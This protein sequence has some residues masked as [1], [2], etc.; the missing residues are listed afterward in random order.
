MSRVRVLI[1]DDSVVVR[2]ILS[3]VLG[4][5]PWIEI[6][7]TAANGRIAVQKLPQLAPDL[8]TLDVEM[9]EL[10]GLETLVEIRRTHPKLPVIMFSTLTERAAST[11]LEAL[12]RG[13]TDYA[14][15]PQSSGG[16][17]GASAEIRAQLLPKIKALFPNRQSLAPRGTRSSVAPPRTASQQVRAIAPV[18]RLPDTLRSGPRGP[19]QLLAIGGSTG[20]P[21]ALA[22]VFAKLPPLNIP[23]VITQ[24]MPPLF[25]RLLSER[26]SSQSKHR[27]IEAKGD[28][29]VEA[30]V[31]Y[32]APGDYHLLF[33]KKGGVVRTVLTK[34]P[35]ENSC[36]PAVDPMF[37]S[38]VAVYGG[39]ILGV[40][41]TGMGQDGLRG[42]E[43][44]REA[45]GQIIVQD[46]ASSVVWGMP[47]YVARAGLADAVLPLDDLPREIV[48]RLGAAAS[49]F[50]RVEGLAPRAREGAT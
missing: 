21:N 2:R 7:G 29:I 44:I 41:L 8:V 5:E 27:V 28:E 24:H 12:S 32:V 48:R 36:R 11:T 31:A 37:R 15:K 20:G 14:T 13:A 4:A 16:I 22:S 49:T 19:Y 40:V 39:A 35:P 42:S 43:G 25:T 18:V 26:L 46:E 3:D 33:E 34:D 38:A 6:V 1:V 47:G 10:D 50:A 45:G 30:G 9:P 23:I 17:V